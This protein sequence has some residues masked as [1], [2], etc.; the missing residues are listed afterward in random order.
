MIVMSKKFKDLKSEITLFLFVSLCFWVL[1][2]LGLMG[3]NEIK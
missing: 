3:I 2:G 1:V